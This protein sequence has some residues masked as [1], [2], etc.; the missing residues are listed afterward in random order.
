MPVYQY[1]IRTETG[2]IT[3]GEILAATIDEATARVRQQGKGYLLDISPSFTAGQGILKKIREFRIE[4]GPGLKDVFTFTRQLSVMIKAGVNVR[5]AIG[6][7]AEQTS[8]PRF[9][10]VLVG[11]REDLEEG[12]PFSEALKKHPKLFSPL[13]INM[14]KASEMSGSF[15]KMLERISVYLHHKIRTRSM[16]RGAMVY[17]LIIA[18]MAIVTTIFLLTFVLP[19]FTLLF[20]GKENLL[21]KP[22]KMLLAA[23]AFLRG[24]W[25][26]VVGIVAALIA[27]FLYFIHT[28]FGRA[29]WDAF[30]LKIPLLGRIFRSLCITRSLQTMGEMVNAGVPMLETLK[31][32]AQVSGNVLYNQMWMQVFRS[33]KS[34]K[35]IA[36]PLARCTLLPRNVVQMISAGEESGNLAEVLT[37]VSEYYDQ[38][39]Q[40]TIKAATSMIEPLMIVMMGFLVGFIAMS[41]ILPIFKMSQLVK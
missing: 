28:P 22:T 5:A 38:E 7:I 18:F 14:V 15:G 21:P 9:R 11:I 34:G 30:K 6:G 2:A 32:T 36:A 27:G 10:K 29:K 4:L 26:I 12:K 31:I 20:A 40:N 39:L 25:Y 24:Y 13:Y 16:V 19:K 3:S 37:D 23:S 17:P 8:N 33:V 1:R 41:V 35:K